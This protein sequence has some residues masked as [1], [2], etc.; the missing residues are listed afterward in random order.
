MADSASESDEARSG[1]EVYGP[2]KMG[3]YDGHTVWVYVFQYTLAD[4]TERGFAMTTIGP[5]NVK[6][7]DELV[8]L[9]EHRAEK[10]RR[11]ANDEMV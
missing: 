9:G 4:G 7:H 5:Y 10:E 6:D 11:L 8:S 3:P 2:Y 1:V